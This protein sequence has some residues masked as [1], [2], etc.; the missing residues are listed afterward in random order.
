[1]FPDIRR[2]DKA[3]SLCEFAETNCFHQT[4]SGFF[5]CQK[6]TLTSKKQISDSWGDDDD[7]DDDDDDVLNVLL[8]TSS[9]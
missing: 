6:V 7:D 5:F 4:E 1:M 2:N 9:D 3:L 8:G